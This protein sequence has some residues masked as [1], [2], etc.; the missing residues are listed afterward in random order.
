MIKKIIHYIILFIILFA[1]D[2][3]MAQEPQDSVKHPEII[4]DELEPDHSYTPLALTLS[5]DGEK[6]VRFLIWHQQWFTTN[7]LANAEDNLQVSTFVRRS[8]FL[9]FAQVSPR[10]LIL[11]HFGLNNLTTQNLTATGN[12]GDGPQIFLHDAWTEFKVSNGKQLYIGAGLHYW[13]GMTRMSNESTLNFMTIDNSRPFAHWHSLGI[14]DQFARHL[15]MYMKGEFGQF[16]YR[17][18]F[19]N[20]LNPANSLGAGKDFGGESVFTYTGSAI[21]NAEGETVGNTIV[22]GYFRYDFLDKE[23]TKLPYQVGTYFGGKK[24]FG[25]GAGFFAQPNGMYNNLLDQHRDVFHFGLDAFLDHPVGKENG[26]NAYAS[27]MQFDYGENFMSR[28]AGTGTNIYGHLG[29]YLNSLKLMPYTSLQIGDYQ[30][31]EQNIT[32]QSFG[33][34]YLLN[35]HH[36]KITLDYHQILNSP[37]E[38]GI[39]ENG[40]PIDVKQLR[41]QLHVWL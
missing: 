2:R 3:L 30:A 23:S 40:T 12:N 31:F 38:V 41:L 7:N 6:Y 34:N 24:V 25:V 8:R 14:T 21:T 10:F 1:F 27:L 36:A 37:L 16:D 20:P 13:K 18:A 4:W 26:I 28:W 33:I 35:K 9:A 5:E 29:F 39:D 19:N 11:T 17:L 22:E 32:A 15:G